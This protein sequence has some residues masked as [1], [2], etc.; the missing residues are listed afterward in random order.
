MNGFRHIRL[1]RIRLKI[2]GCT[3]VPKQ[4]LY[5]LW[6][7]RDLKSMAFSCHTSI[8]TELNSMAFDPGKIR[9]HRPARWDLLQISRFSALR[10]RLR[11]ANGT[12]AQKKT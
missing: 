6:I 7:A 11:A 2:I 12:S 3:Q 8:R 4:R 1:T 9:F 5:L 10:R